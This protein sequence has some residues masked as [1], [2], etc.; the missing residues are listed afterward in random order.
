MRHLD[1]SGETVDAAS[2]VRVSTREQ[3]QGG[4]G[5][6]VQQAEIARYAEKQSL[7]V[8]HH[9]A[10]EGVSGT[11]WDRPGLQGL[12]VE[13]HPPGF[14]VLLVYRLD[15]IARRALYVWRV[16]EELKGA[17]V[18]FCSVTEPQFDTGS[19]M[20]QAMLSM[21]AVF[22]Q[23]E[24]DQI[25][26]RVADRMHLQATLGRWSGRAPFGYRS[27]EGILQPTT[28]AWQVREAFR[29]Y[30]VEHLGANTVARRLT[31]QTGR[32]WCADD[33]WRM[34]TRPVYC[35]RITYNGELFPGQH[36]ALVSLET[37][38]AAQ[39]IRQTRHRLGRER[40]V[41]L[42]SGLLRCRYC[43][44]PMKGRTRE[45]PRNGKPA[46]RVYI[47]SR[48]SRGNCRGSYITV[49]KA[50]RCLVQALRDLARAGA[51]LGPIEM[52]PREVGG[53]ATPEAI[54]RDLEEVARRRRRVIDLAARE[55][56]SEED[57]QASLPLLDR[58]RTQRAE[59][60]RSLERV[61]RAVPS[62]ARA[63]FAEFADLL[64]SKDISRQ[65]K[66]DLL[67]A[68]FER[69]VVEPDSSVTLRL[70]EGT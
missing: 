47:C 11:R 51:D 46:V 53:G 18:D 40:N 13:L 65:E 3:A 68:A 31:D 44:G 9:Y 24:R 35:G 20:G 61:P 45:G 52:V 25:A 32:T 8:T 70:Y 59:A 69:I 41:Y 23:L 17:G 66:R 21:A 38:E 57:L 64:A 19:A 60:L 30:V 16:L 58:E 10:D 26:E 48:H 2:Y 7:V 43:G 56:I 49:R 39:A 67:A 5:L 1:P 36:E 37:W 29:L 6:D 28:D 34:L 42:L 12:L 14:G 15:R 27:E 54:R 50:E 22:A 62:E 4:M 63:R 33:V 55:V